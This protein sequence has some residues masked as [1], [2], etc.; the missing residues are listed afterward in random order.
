MAAASVPAVATHDYLDWRMSE[1]GPAKAI[2]AFACR[3]P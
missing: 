2:R 1:A 3:S